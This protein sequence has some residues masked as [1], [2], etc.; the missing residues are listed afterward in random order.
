MNYDE[1]F[2]FDNL[3]KAHYKSR[4]NKRHKKEVIIFEENLFVNIE[5]LRRKLIKHQY[6]ITSY[7]R[8]VI[9]EPKKRDVAALSYVDRI[10]QH[11]FCDNYLT[12]LLDRRLIYDNAACRKNKGT[13]FARERVTSFL[14]YFYKK[15]RLYGY[16][17]RFDIHHYFDEIDHNVLK[18]K[19]DRIVKDE[20]LNTFCKMIVDS[21][22]HSSGKGLPLGNQTSQAFALYYLDQID[23]L[24]KEKYQIKYYSRYMDDGIIIHEDKGLLKQLLADMEEKLKDLKLT[25]NTK[26][27]IIPLKNKFSYLG[28]N[29]QLLSNGKVIRTISHFKKARIKRYLRA[30]GNN[31]ETIQSLSAY[32][33][34]YNEYKFKANY[35][36]IEDI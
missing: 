21:F 33:S 24:I 5:N 16:I 10:V 1:I 23:R 4:K 27:T 35:L 32:F 25:L 34:K 13:D 3:L 11:C 19:I 15:H 28:I 12:P 14:R 9:F 36:R 18:H 20:T 7:N 26:T 31:D 29:Y 6:Q 22:N 30:N 2:T 8:F 17:L